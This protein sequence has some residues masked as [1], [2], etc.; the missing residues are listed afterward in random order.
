MEAVVFTM[1]TR[2]QKGGD[3]ER[4]KFFIVVA[5]RISM[6]KK[7]DGSQRADGK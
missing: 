5:E 3:E 4:D 1:K 2:T 7:F 6:S